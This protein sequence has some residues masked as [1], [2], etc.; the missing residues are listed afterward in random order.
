M[1]IKLFY[2]TQR[3]LATVLNEIVDGYWGNL[4]SEDALVNHISGIYT[5]NP[6]KIWKQGGFTTIM[7]QQCGKRR[8]EVVERILLRNDLLRHE[9][10]GK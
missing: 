3:E 4:I 2:K 10:T 6:T 1:Q 8:I 5:N 9:S 7:K